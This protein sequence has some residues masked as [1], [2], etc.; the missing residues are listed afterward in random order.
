MRSFLLSGMTGTSGDPL[1][2]LE[3]VLNKAIAIEGGNR[4]STPAGVVEGES[5]EVPEV[6]D[7]KKY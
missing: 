1:R 7:K 5:D 4:K 2:E 3:N 6:K